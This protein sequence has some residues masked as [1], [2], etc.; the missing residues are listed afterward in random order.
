MCFKS[1][2]TNIIEVAR[3]LRWAIFSLLIICM[4]CSCGSFDAA[5]SSADADMDNFH[6]F[7]VLLDL[8]QVDQLLYE[9]YRRALENPESSI[10]FSLIIERTPLVLPTLQIAEEG[11][12]MCLRP[13]MQLFPSV[14]LSGYHGGGNERVVIA[15][16]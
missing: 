12:M 4:D 15:K 3:N 9:E 6:A 1:I 10:V 5:K 13:G 2:S 11:G 8:L 16:R 7:N 14:D